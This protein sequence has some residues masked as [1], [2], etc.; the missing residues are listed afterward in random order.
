MKLEAKFGPVDL[1]VNNAGIML[2]GNA[3]TQNPIEWQQMLNVNV[4]GV[5]NGVK[6]YLRVW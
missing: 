5:L 2:L 4:M 1:L 3:I 6:P